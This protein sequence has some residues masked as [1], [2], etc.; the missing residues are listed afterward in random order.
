MAGARQGAY[1]RK[2]VAGVLSRPTLFVT[3][4]REPNLL[5]RARGHVHK[6]VTAAAMCAAPMR[7][8]VQRADQAA[9]VPQMQMRCD[10]RCGCAQSPAIRC[11]DCRST[12]LPKIAGSVHEAEASVLGQ[13]HGE[14][15]TRRM[16]TRQRYAAVC[17]SY[18]SSHDEFLSDG[19]L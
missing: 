8:R 12:R 2:Q 10:V 11:R 17:T 7:V 14:V 9:D 16:R 15:L 1:C 3:V 18:R 5:V 19:Y 13:Q 4:L 6:T